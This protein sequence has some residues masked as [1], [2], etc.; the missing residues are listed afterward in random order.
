[1][2]DFDKI[3]NENGLTFKDFL[4]FMVDEG[5]ADM[6]TEQLQLDGQMPEFSTEDEHDF[7]RYLI[8]KIKSI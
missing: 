5:Q 7:N 6:I 8:E 2:Y 4:I 3:L 1:M